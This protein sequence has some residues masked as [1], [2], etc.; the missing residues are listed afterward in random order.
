MD[1]L[2]TLILKNLLFLSLE[3]FI[4]NVFLIYNYNFFNYK[5]LVSFDLTVWLEW[6]EPNSLL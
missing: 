4:L 6:T 1:S 5:Q 2:Y 3:V